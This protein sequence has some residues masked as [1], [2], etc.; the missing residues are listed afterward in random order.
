[1][2]RIDLSLKLEQRVY[3]FE[4]KVIDGKPDGSALQQLID[5]A[6]ADK[7]RAPGVDI[8]LIGIEFGRQE[9]NLVDFDSK[10]AP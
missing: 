6:Y 5:K 2:G 3:L 8:T 1:M 4:F 9:R 10:S 7:Y